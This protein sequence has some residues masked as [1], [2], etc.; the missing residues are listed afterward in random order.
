LFVEIVLNIL[1]K[2]G[3]FFEGTRMDKTGKKG[4]IEMKNRKTILFLIQ[5]FLVVLLCA[6]VAFANKASVSIEAP[7]EVPKGTEITIRLTVDHNADNVFHHVEW[8]QL[9]VNNS[10]V[11]YWKYSAFD[12]PSA[13]TFTIEIKYTVNENTEIRGE[14][15]CNLHGS[16]G[17]AFFK[18]AIKE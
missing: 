14:A 16:A 10:Q 8:V 17:P 15:S 7:A 6:N 12:L 9:M 2:Q 11:G 13:A 3:G 5:F 1:K 18:I 4:D